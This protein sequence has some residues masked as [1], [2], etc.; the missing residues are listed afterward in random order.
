MSAAPEESFATERARLAAQAEGK[1]W[2]PVQAAPA[3][4]TEHDNSAL[5][6]HLRAIADK[7]AEG[8]NAAINDSAWLA[9]PK[10]RQTLY[11]FK[12]ATKNAHGFMVLTDV[13]RAA[14]TS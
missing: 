14:L 7:G 3:A 9:D 8:Y 6:P 12:L 11:R 10:N 13:G 5:V 4:T 2:P 1:P